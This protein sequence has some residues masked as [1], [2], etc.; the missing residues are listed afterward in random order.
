M[1]N[2][3]INQLFLGSLLFFIT[4][5]ATIL[6]AQDA[7]PDLGT[8]TIL[9]D[10]RPVTIASFNGAGADTNEGDGSCISE[11]PET[12]TTWFTWEGATDGNLSFTITPTNPNDRIAFVLFN[13]PDTGDPVALRC[14]AACFAGSTGLVENDNDA[15][16]NCQDNPSDAF[17]RA[18]SMQAGL[19]YGLMIEN[20]TSDGGFTI[21]FGGDG[22]LVGPVGEI[23]PSATAACFGQSVTFEE[24]ITFP[25]PNGAITRYDWLVEDG[26]NNITATT[27]VKSPQTFEFATSGSKRIELTVTT[28]TNCASVFETFITINDCC[29]SDN[30]IAIATNPTITE[31]ACPDDTNGAIDITVTNNSDFPT[32]FE[33]SNGA[34]TEDIMNLAPDTY[35]ITVSNAAGCRDSIS[36][37]FVIPNAL[38]AVETVGPPS[39][40]GLADGSITIAASGGRMPYEYD[41][42][43]GN[44]FVPTATL[45]GLD[46]GDY[47]VIVRDASGCTN[48]IEAIELDDRALNIT[49]G[50]ITNPTCGDLTDGSIEI[51]ADNAVGVLTFDFNDGNGPLDPTSL[52][53]LDSG[54]FIIDVFDSEGCTSNPIE[55]TLTKP[56]PIN[57]ILEARRSSCNGANDGTAI[58]TPTGGVPD[59]TYLWSTG[60]TTRSIGNLAP[61]TYSVTVTDANGCTYEATSTPITDPP[62]LTASVTSVQDV[63]CPGEANGIIELM[64]AGGTMPYSYST[65]GLTF[66]QGT[67]ISD[68]PIGDYD[69]I[70]ADNNNCTIMVN[71]TINSPAT[72]SFDVS[73]T[74]NICY[75]EPISF[76]NTSS[77]TQGNITNVTWD[78]G[79]ETA[80]GDNVETSFT[81]IGNPTIQLTVMTDLGC[82]TELTQIL[83]IEVEPCCDQDN[84]LS[85]LPLFEEPLCN[86]SAE[87]S[88]T[89]NPFSIPPITALEWSNEE[90]TEIIENLPAG[91]YTVTVTNDAT[92]QDSTTIVL[93]EPTPISTTFDLTNPTCDVATNG[94]IAISATGGTLAPNGAYEFDFGDGFS[95]DTTQDNLAFGNFS[96]DVR[97]NNNCIITVDTNLIVP[98]TSPINVFLNLIP[99]TCEAAFNGSI[100]IVD[101]GSGSGIGAN[102]VYNFGD[103]FTPNNVADNLAFGDYSLSI[104]DTDNCVLTIDT[105]LAVSTIPPITADISI[106]P[107]SCDIASNGSITVNAM[108]NSD[109]LYDFGEGFSE[110]TVVESLPLGDYAIRIRDADNCELAIDTTV[111]VSAIPPITATLAIIRPSCAEATNGSITVDAIGVGNNMD[112]VYNFGNG[113]DIQ[114]TSERLPVGDYS[115]TIQDRD[116]CALTIDTSLTVDP[117]FVP[118]TATFSN[119]IQP[120]CGGGTDGA[121]TVIPAGE[122]GTDLINYTFDF[123]NGELN[124]NTSSNLAAGP[125]LVVIRNVNNCSIT[126]DTVLSE[127]VLEPTFIVAR[128]TCFGLS[129]GSIIV[130][131]PNPGQ[132][133][134]VYD[135]GDGNG[136]QAATSL[137]NLPQGMYAVQVQDANLCLSEQLNVLIDQPDELSLT[138]MPTDISCFGEGDGQIVATV[139][140]GVGNYTYDWSNG[141]ITNTASNL[142]AGEYFLAVTDGNDCPVNSD[143]VPIIEPAELNVAVGQVDNVLCFGETNGAITIDA[144]GGSAPF[145]Y[146]LDGIIFQPT[147]TLGSLPAGDYMVIVRDSRACEVPTEN[148]TVTEP[149]EFLVT[150]NVDAP[151]AKLGFTINL[152]AETST[153]TGG[154]NFVWSTPD[155]IVCNNCPNFSTVPLGSTTYTVTAVN[156]ENCQATAS[157]DVRVSLDRPVYIPNIF[158]PNGDGIND[159]FFIPFSPAMTEVKSLQI[160]D[161]SGALVFEAFDIAQGEEILKAWDGEFNGTQIRQGVF[162]ISAQIAFVDGQVL[163]YQSDVTLIT[164]E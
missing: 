112:L 68:L 46:T 2:S 28:N 81:A 62:V 78:F 50:D 57:G 91:A 3:F 85:F 98:D 101:T 37:T 147:S 108:G 42:G 88:I 32:V 93:E 36:H 43:D 86:G 97:D 11:L 118:I 15:V 80:T 10:K 138:T 115:V 61:G 154:I 116:N 20:T 6:Q 142:E 4:T 100:T 83:D 131:V 95:T 132:G 110:E 153:N 163:P 134:F 84:G 66:T 96:I 102:F 41:F 45:N 1:K 136:F 31:I 34:D 130:D 104:R 14:G 25:I 79:A 17:A 149:A 56:T 157:V 89:L 55:F 77:F 69:I 129:D 114:T 27:L 121:I 107:V 47:T 148:I 164:S 105:T 59:Y 53:R 5:N 144:T 103:G 99:P 155:S 48:T 19:I 156:S 94:A 64:V 109:L 9:C 16:V 159:E 92:C 12:N 127:P 158:S 7:Q 152:S 52:T 71:A 161:R 22:E 162:V 8:A 54:T 49:I 30:S 18:L 35:T 139:T 113:F 150:A 75:G 141:Q 120:S 73:T 123:G 146:S 119:I 143:L 128:P 29:E 74:T 38:T 140:G 65:D 122:S 44:G 135:F 60:E 26:D 24:N 137:T 125:Q 117:D 33:W 21:T 145:E 63:S 67:T 58:I 72:I 106:V 76:T 160:F 151:E 70:V 39:C 133:P 51:S 111:A 40:G 87:G 124:V 23:I 90:N 82:E 126:L 13:L